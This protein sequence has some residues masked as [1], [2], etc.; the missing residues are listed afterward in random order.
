M[1]AN[2]RPFTYDREVS[3][4]YSEFTRLPPESMRAPVPASAVARVLGLPAST[5]QRRV[6]AMIDAGKL[7]RKPGGLMVTE[8]ALNAEPAIEDSRTS[9]DHTRQI[10]ARL[11][12]GGF[13]FDD[14]ALCYLEE[15]PPLVDFG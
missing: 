7:L 14:P 8:A 5:V 1:C 12:A 9:T 6:N 11:A 4:A 3:L 2:A 13:R 10:F 15:R